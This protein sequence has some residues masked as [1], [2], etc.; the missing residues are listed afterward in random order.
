[1]SAA[2]HWSWRPIVAVLIGC[3]IIFFVQSRLPGI[4]RAKVSVEIAISLPVFIQ[5][6]LAGGDRY[7]AASWATIRS[8]VT[9]TSKMGS[10]DFQVLAQVQ[11]DASWL[12]PA[13]ED[14]YYTA[15]A[16]LPWE[17]Q[18]EATQVILRRATLARPYDYQ[19][20][21]YYAFN[22]VQFMGDYLRA[23][24]WLLLAAPKLP[25]PDERVLLEHFAARWLDRTQDVELAA[26]IVDA[27]AAQAKRKDFA[28]Y[29]RLRAQRLH[30]LARLRRAVLA[31]SERYG[32]PPASL[33][34][35]VR[36]GIIN[37]LPVDPF[38]YGFGL[39]PNGIPV[40][41]GRTPQ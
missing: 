16:I 3:L 20:A 33:S 7:L 5:V 35:L 21:F 9:E 40:L 12:N 4:K 25:K 22:L 31:Y 28:D 6:V 24:E 17:G 13:H 11:R 39:D 15:T 18:V 19:P 37:K 23:S 2:G 10:D 27:M 36:T 34:E 38:G 32:Q 8:L 14:N 1:M 41:L 26:R 29:L 30:D